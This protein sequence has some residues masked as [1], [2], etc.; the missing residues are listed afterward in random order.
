MDNV[1]WNMFDTGREGGVATVG[2][3]RRV[4]SGGF[5]FLFYG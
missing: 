4:G 3:A 5:L 1:I 2:S